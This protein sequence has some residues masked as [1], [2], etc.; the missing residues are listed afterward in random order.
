MMQ[1]NDNHAPP[2]GAAV[3]SGG[4]SPPPPPD[5]ELIA[6]ELA[7]LGE[8]PVTDEDFA[9]ATKA[10]DQDVRTAATLFAISAWKAPVEGL[11]PLERHRVWRQ[12]AQRA[13]QPVADPQQPAANNTAGWRGLVAGLALVAGV[14]LIPSFQGSSVP[15][16]QSLA[17]TQSMGDVARL[18]VE[19]VPG[20]RDGSRARLLADGYQQRLDAAREQ[21]R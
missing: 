16:K 3:G 21:A 13:P 2:S 7:A 4:V 19:A 6:A 18:A 12:I 5:A 15:S 17:E 10:N 20:E 1:R 8:D 9:F 11:L 14:A